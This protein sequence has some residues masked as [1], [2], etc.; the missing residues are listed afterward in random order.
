MLVLHPVNLELEMLAWPLLGNGNTNDWVFHRQNRFQYSANRKKK[1]QHLAW[2]A[3]VET[4][5]LK[6]EAG[7]T[8]GENL[9]LKVHCRKTGL[10]L[11]ASL[12]LHGRIFWRSEMSARFFCLYSSTVP[13]TNSISPR[14]EF[15]SAS[16]L[17]DP[18]WLSLAEHSL[19]LTWHCQ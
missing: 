1:Q 16:R 15:S 17:Q 3:G 9:L 6:L 12:T 2:E 14:R 10:P 5:C 11:L 19:Q 4:V 18:T 7:D 8:T 13:Q